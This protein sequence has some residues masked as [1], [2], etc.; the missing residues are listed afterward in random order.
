[1]SVPKPVQ[2]KLQRVDD[3]LKD[4]DQIIRTFLHDRPYKAT[5][6]VEDGGL[7]HKIVWE[8]YV[9]PPAQI[10]QVAAD[11]IHNL[12][13]SLDHMVVALAR[14]GASATDTSLTPA[15]ERKLQFPI[16]ASLDEWHT[17]LSRSRLLHV[18]PVARS[19]IKDNQPFRVTPARPKLAHL[20]TLSELDD[21]DKHRSVVRTD[22]APGIVKV[23]WPENL[24]NV[25]LVNPYP[26]VDP[27]RGE[28][29]GRFTF[30]TPHAEDELP[31]DFQWGFTMWIGYWSFYD[32]RYMIDNYVRVVHYIVNQLASLLP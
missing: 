32:V 5:R 11:A 8:E 12:R 10:G 18:D 23:N 25:Q 13:S 28:E 24:K 4:L 16:V 1:M 2:V 19:I 20:L 15:Q 17:Q 30:D 26:P 7:I 14:H 31:L 27:I 3:L 9:E 22:L 21:A 6:V 29:L